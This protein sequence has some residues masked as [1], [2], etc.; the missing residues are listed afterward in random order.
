MSRQYGS[1]WPSLATRLYRPLLLGTELFIWIVY[2]CLID[3]NGMSNILGL[4][5]A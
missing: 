4:S 2:S 1:L 3:F 5:Y